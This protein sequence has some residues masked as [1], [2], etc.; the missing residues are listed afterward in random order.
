MNTQKCIIEQQVITEIFI[1]NLEL[2]Y[3]KLFIKFGITND[4]FKNRIR[5]N[6]KKERIYYEN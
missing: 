5:I 3:Y 4:L 6:K 1:Y 2:S